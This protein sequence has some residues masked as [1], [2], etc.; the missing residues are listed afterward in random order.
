MEHATTVFIAD[1]AE[2][3]CG[4]LTAAL[5]RSEGFQ[6]IGS[7]SDGEQPSDRLP[8]ANRMYWFWI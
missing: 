7:A 6:V 5:H 3:F 1:S 8:N 4:N 2:E